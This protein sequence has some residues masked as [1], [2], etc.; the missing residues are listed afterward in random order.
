MIVDS[1]R[2]K[3][4]EDRIVSSYGTEHVR[5]WNSGEEATLGGSSVYGFL[6][7]G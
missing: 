3:V 5:I 7:S 2:S 4:V 6:F 1:L